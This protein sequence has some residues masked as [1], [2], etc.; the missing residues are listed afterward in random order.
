MM[1]LFSRYR[2]S[3]RDN[4]RLAWPLIIGQV[5]QVL[6]LVSD[7]IMVGQ[8]G[9]IPLAA[10]S[11][12]IAVFAIFFVV[13]LGISFALPPL[14][15]EAFG[16]DDDKAISESLFNSLVINLGYAIFVIIATE[17]GIPLLD[18]LGQDPAVVKE[19]IPYLRLSVYSMIPFMAFS[20]F[21]SLS[22][23]LGR[24]SISM[25]AM[26]IGNILNIALNYIFIFGKFGMPALGVVGAGLSSLVSRFVMILAWFV[27]VWQIDS[28]KKFLV[29]MHFGMLSKRNFKKVL[30]IG[31]VTSLQ[32]LFEVSIFS[33]STLLMGRI[34][35]TAQAAHQIALNIITI[36]FMVT[37]GF[38]IAATIKVG[39]LYGKAQFEELRRAG[40]TAIAM[41]AVFM[42][43]MAFV[44]LASR[45]FLPSIYIS[46][47][48]VINL[49]ASLLIFAAMFQIPDGMQVSAIGALRGLQDVKIPALLTFVSYICIGIPASFILAFHLDFGPAGI[50]IGLLVG[51]SLSALFNTLRFRHM[52]SY[53]ISLRY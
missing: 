21:R 14:V 6:V 11:L 28:L 38:S 36:T 51:L 15:A 53:L 31:I 27:I 13:G 33:G 7:N 35:E 8:M 50:W 29:N 42:F 47:P 48:V 22:D 25:N 37:S 23:G 39:Q 40:Y 16:M 34:G 20:A 9:T 19:A 49:S 5:G 3:I 45:F 41:S 4:F 32:M 52:V 2:S 18:H 12:G 26:I 10:I 43:F 17:A 24:T 46:D 1:R 44:L 30:S